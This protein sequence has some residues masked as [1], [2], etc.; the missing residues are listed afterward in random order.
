M[1]LFVK[2]SIIDMTEVK[3]PKIVITIKRQ[4]VVGDDNDNNDDTLSNRSQFYTKENIAQQCMMTLKKYVDMSQFDHIFEPSAGTGSFFKLIPLDK[5]RGIDIDPKCDGV[6]NMNYYDFTPEKNCKYLVVGN[7][8]FGKIGSDAIKFFNKS[9]EFCEVIAFILPRTFKRVS[10]QNKLNLHFHLL[11]TEDLPLKPCCFSPP[12]TAKCCFQI[13]V[14]KEDKRA[15]VI[16]DK[17]HIDFNFLKLG[18]LDEH[19]QPTPPQGADFAMKAYGSNCGEIVCNNLETL[20]P[21]SWHWIKSNIDKEQLINNFKSLDYSMSR[22]TVRQD[23]IG[24]QEVI[25][26]YKLRFA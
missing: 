14:H 25:Y 6:E 21:K 18:P 3:K 26:L 9:A 7:P 1:F 20:R 19:R 16:Y 15:K 5:R 8:P 2:I 10:V 11:H 12:M 13:W 24:Q 17:S 22:D 4:N 23:S